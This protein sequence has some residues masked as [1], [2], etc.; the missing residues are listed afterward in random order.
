MP[1]T[2]GV[3]LPDAT[4]HRIVLEAV[5]SRLDGE[6]PW[7]QRPAHRVGRTLIGA[8]AAIGAG[9]EVEHVLPGEV[10][11]RLY[12]ERF[13]LIQLLVADAPSHRLHGSPVQ[14]REVDVEQRRLDVELN[15][16]RPVAQQKEKGQYIQQ[17]GAAVEIPERG[18]G[19]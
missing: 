1:P 13:H 7:R 11:E 14:L 10:F 5:V 15:S 6:E 8:A 17:V 12:A 18:L 16:K 9:V 3:P 19:S 2:K 4:K